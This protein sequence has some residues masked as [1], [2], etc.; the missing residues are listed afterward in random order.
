MKT[1][2]NQHLAEFAAQ[3]HQLGSDS[4]ACRQEILASCRAAAH[5]PPGLFSMTEST[6]GGKT[7]SSLAF[8][9]EHAERHGLIG[10]Y[11]T[12]A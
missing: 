11:T 9:R 10:I 6:G 1:R 2:L 3:S 7:L 8:A 5:Q 12:P 4:Q